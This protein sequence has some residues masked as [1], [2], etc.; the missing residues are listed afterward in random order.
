MVRLPLT[1]EQLAAGK[2]LGEQLRRAR[3]ERTLTDV[4][5]AAA[6]SP[7]TLRKIE[8]G[9]LATPAFATIAALARVL[10]LSLDELAVSALAR[11]DLK[12]TG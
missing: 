8:T 12:H 5:Q 10:D 4:A 6:I 9:R 11:V 1:A 3:G 7:E 2:R